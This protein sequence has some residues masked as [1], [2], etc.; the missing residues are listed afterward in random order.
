M[1][2]R[3]RSR[4]QLVLLALLF[5]SPVIAAWLAWQYANQQGVAVTTNAGE[6]VSPARPLAA[7]PWVG[8]D[9]EPLGDGLLTGR[10]S[11]VLLAGDGC[12]AGC[13][14]RLYL[15][16]QVR[17]SVNKDMSRVQ[18]VLVLSRQPSDLAMLRSE[19]PDLVIAVV[20]DTDLQAFGAQFDAASG[21]ADRLYLV[22]PL[23]NLMMRYTTDVPAKGV[24]K[25]LRRLLKASQVG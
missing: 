1:P 4:L 7:A 25:D 2:A 11:Y 19:H 6:L 10:W 18:R 12:D 13:Q 24:L 20:S 15:S 9:G 5:A 3:N 17:T 8:S 21:S 23:G 16:R 22:D 14:E